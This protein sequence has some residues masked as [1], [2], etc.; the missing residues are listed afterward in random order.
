[1]DDRL[2]RF[3]A[4]IETL[5]IPILLFGPGG[6]T[7]LSSNTVEGALNSSENQCVEYDSLQKLIQVRCESIHLTDIYNNLRNPTVLGIE[8][9]SDE[10]QAKVWILNA[11]IVVDKEGSL[12]IDSSDT[13]W[14]KIIP[15]PTVQL[16]QKSAN[17]TEDT[18][19]SDDT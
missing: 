11:G 6:I 7:G 12:I 5:L 2:E 19:Y 16:K 18:N 14:L 3:I 4:I 13:S 8:R 1:M 17:A 9:G 10:N 15:T